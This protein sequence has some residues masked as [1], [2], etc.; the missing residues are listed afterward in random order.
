MSNVFTASLITRFNACA[1]QW[2]YRAFCAFCLIRAWTQWR[3]EGFWRLGR[4]WE[5][6]PLPSA[7]QTGKRKGA[8]PR[9]GGGLGRSPSHQRFWD[10]GAIG[11]EWSPFLNNVN[12]IFNFS[13]QT[14]KRRRRSAA[15]PC[16]LGVNG[17]HFWIALTPFSTRRVR[18]ARAES[19]LSFAI[20]G[21]GAEPQPPT[22]LGAFGCEWNPFLNSLNIIFNS[23]GAHCGLA[24]CDPHSNSFFRL[25]AMG[26]RRQWYW[27]L[28]PGTHRRRRACAPKCWV[29]RAFSA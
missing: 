23:F 1:A 7:C 5:L 27:C 17:T 12:T 26:R 8:L 10:L 6:A 3:T 29:I 20:G 15:L 24:V 28:P 13:C 2:I 22:L 16:Y 9:R 14:G 25:F 19:A 4:R 21:S 11:S 18:L